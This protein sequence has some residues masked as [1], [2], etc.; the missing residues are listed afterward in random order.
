MLCRLAG[1]PGL[2]T[3]PAVWPSV[4]WSTVAY[5]ALFLL[6]SVVFRRATLLALAYALF[7]ETL[8]GNLPGIAKRLAISFYTRCL[9]FESA[10]ELDLR[11]KG[12]Y[13]PEL[14]LPISG[15]A[16]EI[17]LLTL[18]GALFLIALT[19][20]SVREYVSS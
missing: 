3:W 12:L 4:L 8:V 11:L 14:F 6:F 16:A 5:V 13:K 18:C 19:I 1:K 15:S 20:F 7:L 17:V 2:E 10:D 9:V